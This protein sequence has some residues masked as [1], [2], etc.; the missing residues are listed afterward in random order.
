MSRGIHCCPN[1]FISVA[2]LAS[3]CCEKYVYICI[4]DCVGAVYELPMIPS[5]I[6]SETFLHKSGAVQR[7][8]GYLLL[9]RQRGGDWANT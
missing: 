4:S 7:V 2:Q 8:D 6:A 5:N 3:L 1:L 9:G